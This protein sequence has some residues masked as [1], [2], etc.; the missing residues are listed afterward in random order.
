MGE[1]L[2]QW[3]MQKNN[4]ITR[5][6]YDKRCEN[7]KIKN[8]IQQNIASWLESRVRKAIKKKKII[9]HRMGFLSGGDQ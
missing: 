1:R 5:L 3:D 8:Y 9:L 6:N 7:E 4:V 2:L